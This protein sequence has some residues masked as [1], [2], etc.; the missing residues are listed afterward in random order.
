MKQ[1]VKCYKCDIGCVVLIDGKPV[2]L[3]NKFFNYMGLGYGHEASNMAYSILHM[4]KGI[5]IAC[6]CCLSFKLEFVVNW[7]YDKEYW[8]DVDE[9]LANKVW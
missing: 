3:I 8:I 6:F 2:P 4:L 9:W 1:C 7:E 5:D